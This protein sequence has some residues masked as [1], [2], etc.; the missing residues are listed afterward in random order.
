[1]G[2]TPLKINLKAN[3]PAYLMRSGELDCQ[4]AS[5]QVR[6]LIGTIKFI[7]LL[8]KTQ[9][10]ELPAW[11]LLF[12]G[13]ME[14]YCQHSFQE[15]LIHTLEK[16]L[17]L[18]LIGLESIRRQVKEIRI[19]NNQGTEVK[20]PAD[21]LT[22][23]QVAQI[24]S[25]FGNVEGDG[26]LGVEQ[27]RGRQMT[28]NV[29]GEQK[30]KVEGTV[31]MLDSSGHCDPMGFEHFPFSS[32]PLQPGDFGAIQFSSNIFPTLFRVQANNR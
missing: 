2:I 21:K 6:A 12:S 11:L 31:E 10:T 24:M 32:S 27:I 25:A 29:G 3:T 16:S 4:K 15:D 20:I 5:A 1:M 13:G 19:E 17:G 30:S 22:T 28:I 8:R 23:F 14:I 7:S 9:N 18:E 26:F